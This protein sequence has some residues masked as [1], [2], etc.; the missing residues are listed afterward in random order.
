MAVKWADNVEETTASTGTGTIDLDGATG[1]NQT[2]VAGLG[3]GNTCYYCISSNSEYGV[4]YGTVT[5]AATDTLSRDSVLASSNNDSLVSFSAGTKNVHLLPPFA[6]RA[7]RIFDR[8]RDT[9]VDTDEGFADEDAIRFDAAGSE[10]ATITANGLALPNGARIDEFSTDGA[11]G[12][13]S[14]IAVPTERAV[15]SYVD[16]LTSLSDA[17]G[18]TKIQVE[19]SANENKIRFDT[20]G[21]E[22]AILDSTAL[23]LSVPVE[24]PDGTAAAPGIAF[25]DDTDTGFYR[26]SNGAIGYAA[27]GAEV[28]RFSND[29]ALF[30]NE[31]LNTK[32]GLGLT[33]NQGTSDNEILSLKSSDVTH[34]MSSETETDTWLNITKASATEGGARFR[35]FSE[36]AIGADVS[37]AATVASSTQSTSGSG[38]VVF[39]GYE[40]SG[41]TYAGVNDSRNMVAFINSGTTRVIFTGN[42]TAYASDTSW[43]T[44]LDTEDDIKALRMLDRVQSTKGVMESAWDSVIGEDWDYLQ[45]IGVAGSTNPEKGRPDMFAIQPTIK[46]TMGAVWYMAQNFMSLVEMLERRSPGAKVEL[47][48]IM[49]EKSGRAPMLMPIATAA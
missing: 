39:R 42:G 1:G 40:K 36:G 11:L 22:R 34:G 25:K 28:M 26:I 45:R 47:A 12:G 21:T 27:S 44:A 18:D 30:L 31:T 48:Q 38:A 3:T 6:L 7:S 14:D 29:G 4:S 46:L 19:E 15:K 33:I 17:D 5:D 49:Q 24:A 2:F 13:N 20:G 16:G 41:T 35:G 43:A 32:M 37:G 8:D 23:E 10:I 9:K